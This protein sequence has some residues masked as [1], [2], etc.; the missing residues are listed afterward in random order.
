MN[1]KTGLIILGSVASAYGLYKVIK[2]KKDK[3][4]LTDKEKQITVISFIV[5]VVAFLYV[6][7]LTTK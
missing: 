4:P 1:L 5:G 6:P 2:S 3:I 7:V